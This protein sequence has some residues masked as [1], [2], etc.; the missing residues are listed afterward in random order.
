LNIGEKLVG[1]ESAPEKKGIVEAIDSLVLVEDFV[2][3]GYRCEEYN[4]INVV[5]VWNPSCALTM[6]SATV[7][8][9]EGGYERMYGYR[10]RRT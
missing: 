4:R 1:A 5:K 7:S 3:S 9:E 2:H 10:Q 6:A 8:E